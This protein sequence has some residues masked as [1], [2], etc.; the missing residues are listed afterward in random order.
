MTMR[1][2]PVMEHWGSYR[3]WLG[4]LN[5][6]SALATPVRFLLSDYNALCAADGFTAAPEAR[7]IHWLESTDGIHIKSGG[8]GLIRRVAIGVAP[9][10]TCLLYT[11]DAA[12][13]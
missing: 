7:F 3:A 2:L 13:E 9:S 6:D 10:S 1:P 4:T 5:W 12:D 11:S 8:R